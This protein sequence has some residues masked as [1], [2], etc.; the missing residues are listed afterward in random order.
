[1][2]CV[3]FSIT[4]RRFMFKKVI[5][6]TLLLTLLIVIASLG[7]DLYLKVNY[8]SKISN[9]LK[10]TPTAQ[11]ALVFGA[12]VYRNRKPSPILAERLDKAIELYNNKKVKKIILSGDSHKNYNEV[13]VM[14]NYLL[15]RNI[16]GNDIFLDYRGFRSLDSIYHTKRDYGAKS[17]LLVSQSYHLIRVLF[18][19]D[20][21]GLTAFG[22]TA[23]IGKAPVSFKLRFRE[24]FARLLAFI[25]V[26]VINKVPQKIKPA[27][28]YGSG[29]QTWKK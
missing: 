29:R 6:A 9:D 20:S 1:M 15:N 8:Q 5:Y 26:Y 16:N 3:L 12:S 10:Q 28:L 7:I 22:Y 27:S 17:V 14:K 13:K 4:E 11:V 2:Q 19:A 21:I 24:Y 23:T 25:E 18:L